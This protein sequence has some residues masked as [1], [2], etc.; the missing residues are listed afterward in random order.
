MKLASC[1]SS[2]RHAGLRSVQTQ[3]I[4]ASNSFE[5]NP[6]KMVLEL[7]IAAIEQPWNGLCQGI[8]DALC[9]S[10]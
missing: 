2:N 9:R 5:L 3:A 1:R 7:G 6:I 10:F 8:I 4:L